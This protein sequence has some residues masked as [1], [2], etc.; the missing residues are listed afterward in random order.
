MSICMRTFVQIWA[1]AI[2]ARIARYILVV[3][4]A[5]GRTV[6]PASRFPRPVERAASGTMSAAAHTQPSVVPSTPES[7][8]FTNS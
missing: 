8:C 1:A 7:P 5:G 4:T 6:P 3:G 2:G